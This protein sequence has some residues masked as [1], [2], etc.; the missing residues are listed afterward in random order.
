M[1]DHVRLLVTLGSSTSLSSTMRLL[2]GRLTPLLRRHTAAWQQSFYDHRLRSEE[3]WAW[4]G[5]L[6]NERCPEPAWLE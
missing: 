2:K 3:D 4:F 6:T 5:S 1:P